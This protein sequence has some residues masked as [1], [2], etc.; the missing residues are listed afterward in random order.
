MSHFSDGRRLRDVFQSITR[1][2]WILFA[3]EAG[4]VFGRHAGVGA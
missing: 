3:Q 1:D 4:E 2:E